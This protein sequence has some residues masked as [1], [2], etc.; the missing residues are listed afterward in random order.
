MAYAD[1][2]LCDVCGNKAFYDSNLGYEFAE[3]KEGKFVYPE[4]RVRI[5]GEDQPYGYGLGRLGDWAVLCLEC[6]KTH[7]T[8]I[9]KREAQ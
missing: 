6:S 4:N 3:H 7:K 9:V 2:R 8:C 5:A 1:Y